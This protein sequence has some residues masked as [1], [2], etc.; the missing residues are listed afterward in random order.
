MSALTR[1]G[2]RGGAVLARV[3]A[4]ALVA[5]AT[6]AA[7]ERV[8]RVSRAEQSEL[9]L[10]S[11]GAARLLALGFDG[12]VSDW[13]WIQAVQVVGAGDGY[14]DS[15]KLGRLVDVVTSVNPWVGHPY[16]LAAVFL[17]QSPEQ[18][19]EANRL[20]ERGIAY[21]PTDWRNRFYLGFNH[22][23]YLAEYDLA[24][25]AIESALPLRGGPARYGGPDVPD[26]PPY[27]KL[28][29]ARLRAHAGDLD[30]AAAFLAALA[31]NAPDEKARAQYEEALVQLETERRARLLDAARERYR[32]RH[33]RDI[34]S[35]SDLVRG[36]VLAELPPEPR[37]RGW[38][39]DPESGRIVS[40]YY[41]RRYEPHVHWSDRER[42]ERWGIE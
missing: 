6:A 2:A 1:R 22:F 32:E 5:A 18:V 30:T 35:V 31:R 27:L 39:L 13:F 23:F 24:A 34:A 19:R 38:D 11:P 14:R 26:P 25:D 12:L 4:I 42:R 17:T 29:A 37:G 16:R 40:R 8:P 10:P 3:A 20:L 21:H 33:R 7:H 28:L 36:G 15:D 9:F 41:A